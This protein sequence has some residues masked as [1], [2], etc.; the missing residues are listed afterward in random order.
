MGKDS[1]SSRQ[2]EGVSKLNCF[3][4]IDEVNFW[5]SRTPDL[6]ASAGDPPL[7][8][9]SGSIRELRREWRKA[10]FALGVALYQFQYE[11]EEQATNADNR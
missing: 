11:T 10:G 9:V 4:Q 6:I 5:L 3:I 7:P 1:D 2:D 8:G